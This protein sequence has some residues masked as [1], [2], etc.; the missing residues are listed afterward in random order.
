MDILHLL[1]FKGVLCLIILKWPLAWEGG[2]GALGYQMDTH[3]QTA[4]NI[5][6]TVNAKNEGPVSSFEC[7]KKGMWGRSGGGGGSQLQTKILIEAIVC[8][9]WK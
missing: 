3:C 5:A 4:T 2:G 8:M 6:E 7:K 9:V 1:Y